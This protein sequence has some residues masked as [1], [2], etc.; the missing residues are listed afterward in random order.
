MVYVRPLAKGMGEA[1]ARRTYFR[2]EDNENM[3]NV[4]TRVAQGNVSIRE[5]DPKF[6]KEQQDKEFKN[7]Q[8]YISKGLMLTAGRHLQHG[9]ANQKNQCQELFTNC[10]TA[11][12]TF[13]SFYLLLCGSGVGRCYDTDMM[14]V[15]WRNLP[16]IIPVL[17]SKHKDYHTKYLTPQ[18]ALYD[19]PEAETYV[20]DDSREGWAKTI[21]HLENVAYKKKHV[22]K[23]LLIDCS[24]IRCSGTPIKGMQGKPAPGPMH[25]MESLLEIGQI[26]KL[27][28]L[29]DMTRNEQTMRIDHALAKCVVA[30]GSRRSSRIACVYWK[31]AFALK[32]IDLKKEGDLWSANNSVL[33]DDAFFRSLKRK[34]KVATKVAHKMSVAA[35]YD[36]SGEPGG[37]NI[38][39]L[40]SNKHDVEKMLDYAIAGELFES[41]GVYSVDESSKDLI[42]VLAAI[43]ILKPNQFICNPCGEIVLHIMG[44]YCVISDL[45][46]YMADDL[47]EIIAAAEC[48]VRFL[49]NVNMMPSLY[50]K[51]VL[52]TQRIGVGLTGIHEWAWDKYGYTFRDLLDEEKSKDFWEDVSKIS[53]ACVAEADRYAE[54]LGVTPPHT[55]LTIKPSGSVSKLHGISEGAHLPTLKWF[56]RNVQFMK[57]DPLVEEYKEKGYPIIWGDDLNVYKDVN[58]VGF[59]TEPEICKIMPADKITTAADVTLQEQYD[60]I[61]LLEKYWLSADR[62]NQVSYTAKYRPDEISY[63]EFHDTFFTNQKEVRCF[64]VMPQMENTV[65]EYQ[66]EQPISKEK[67]DALVAKIKNDGKEEID[68]EHLKCVGGACP[69]DIIN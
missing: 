7:I 11:S 50:R 15:D 51:E 56:L 6:S 38:S 21:E 42:R 29:T 58:I 69:I 49:M 47:E 68:V 64:T 39:K 13:L 60:W 54:E 9:D 55:V 24:P 62:G 23:V 40:N 28:H 18:Q 67:F 26:V 5:D 34:T 36:D 3:F 10:S 31:D 43:T 25:F 12:T 52:R 27:A 17:D 44:A 16:K 66:P 8:K 45:A 41:N 59:P 22:G 46:P 30:G 57:N 1:V 61:K 35:Y 65:Y 4:A 19:Y 32:F 20:V 33:L 2:K 63:E 14:V 37:I 53:Q 48:S